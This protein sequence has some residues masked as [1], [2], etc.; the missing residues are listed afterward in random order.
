MT[1]DDCDAFTQGALD[2]A[3]WLASDHDNG[4]E[5]YEWGSGPADDAVAAVEWE[6]NSVASLAEECAAFQA[7]HAADL[8]AAYATGYT[9]EQAGHDFWL[10]RNHHGA[11][12][13]DRGLGAIGDRLTQACRPWGSRDAFHSGGLF[14]LD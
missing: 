7:D 9:P 6:P 10:T 8:E 3:A 1:R 2:C 4:G 14:S 5:A 12:F 13:W 11:G